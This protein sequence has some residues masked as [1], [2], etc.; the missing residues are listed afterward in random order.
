M[1]LNAL[2]LWDGIPPEEGEIE[3][4]WKGSPEKAEA[5]MRE[6]AALIRAARPDLVNLAEVENEAALKR[7]NEKFLPGLGYRPYFAEG[8]D[9]F[10]GQDMGLLS[11]FPLESYRY[12]RRRGTSGRTRKSVSKN[13]VATL[14]LRDAKIA[15]IGLHLLANPSAADRKHRRQAQADA[16]LQMAREKQRAGYQLIVWGDFNDYDGAADSLDSQRNRPITNVMSRLR[17]LDPDNPQDDLVNAVRFVPAGER[18]TS[19][20]DRNHNRRVDGPH[21]YSAI[22]HI[23]LSPTLAAAVE[24]VEIMQTHDPLQVSDHFPI[25]VRLRFS[26]AAGR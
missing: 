17:Q 15:L 12:D 16:I 3:F 6:I 23:L 25:V 26:P 24:E 13:Y 18:Y 4:P 22:D 11:R 2:F 21:E 19:F 5:H 9:H 20:Y 10:T 8:I 14:H 7:F 1:H